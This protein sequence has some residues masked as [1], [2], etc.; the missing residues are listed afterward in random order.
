VTEQPDLSVAGDD[1]A[2]A[3]WVADHPGALVAFRPTAGS[4]VARAVGLAPGRAGAH[5]ITLDALRLSHG[6]LAVN[7]VVLGT[8]PD[9][10]TR[11]SRALPV[12]LH[13]DGTEVATARTTTIVVATGQ[14]LRGLDVVPRGH[15]GDGRLE[16]HVY[17]LRPAERRPMRA[18]L[19]HGT[20]V[21]HPRIT[22]RP[23]HEVEIVAGRPVPVEIDGESRAP[24]TA[25]SITVVAGAYRLLV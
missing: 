8:P 21:P 14:Y 18:R 25:L 6:G 16:V 24:L 9:R 19:Q 11:W 22:A 15:P 20:H 3:Q 5:P 23:G 7:M 10:L 17:R 12:T 13:V 1:R 2:L 4:D